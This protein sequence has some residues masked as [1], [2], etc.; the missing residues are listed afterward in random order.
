MY[1]YTTVYL[2]INV[3]S[4][5]LAHCYVA[6]TKPRSGKLS[7]EKTCT[8]FVVLWVFAKL[9][10]GKFGE[11]VSFWGRCILG[12]SKSEQSVKVFSAKIVFFTNLQKNFPQKF[13]TLQWHTKPFGS[14]DYECVCLKNPKYKFCYDSVNVCIHV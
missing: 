9:F 5:V 14:Y 8:N 10:S 4:V 7:R 6:L 1:R 12:H 3:H 2:G 11:V 13:P